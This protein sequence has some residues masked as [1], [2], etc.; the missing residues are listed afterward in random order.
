MLAA[1]PGL[2]ATTP[3][4]EIQR[5]HPGQYD[6]ALLRTLQ[7][8]VRTWS[9]SYGKEREMFFAPAHPP[10][11]LGLSDFT[12]AAVLQATIAGAT[13]LH[14]LYKF[15]M[16]YSGWRYLEVVPG[17]ESFMAL[18]SGLQNAA[19]MLDG[20]PEEHRRDSRAAAFKNK[21]EHEL[22]TRRNEALC[23]HY[24]MCPSRNNL[25]VSHENGL[26]KSPQ[27]T[28]KRTM[29]QASL[30]REHRDVGDLD[31]FCFFVVEVFGRLK[32]TSNNRISP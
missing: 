25:R 9:A 11:C 12:H 18:S 32:A 13:L 20:V 2:T 31:A 15:A 29:E 22:L 21:A 14:L 3:L 8:R 6:N 16:A 23:Q 4:K 5:H 10:G 19:W 17:G 24:G 1:A 26:I 30:L 7:R 27:G 28:L